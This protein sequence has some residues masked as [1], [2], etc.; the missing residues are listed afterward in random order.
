MLLRI[1]A[2]ALFVALIIPFSL[3]GEPTAD[4]G[5]SIGQSPQACDAAS[6][7]VETATVDV[8]SSESRV[9]MNI[10]I[11]MRNINCVGDKYSV[12]LG[13]KVYS[14]DG[15]VWATDSLWELPL[16]QEEIVPGYFAD[17]T[18]SD[19]FSDTPDEIIDGSTVDFVGF[20]G[21]GFPW[22]TALFDGFDYRALVLSVSANSNYLG[23]TIALYQYR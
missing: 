16:W 23:R 10:P 9:F 17:V 4:S 3:F 21:I 13:W 19:L 11:R 20:A 22:D 12:A 7:S 14:P 1:W 8:D 6:V 15:A 5:S 2:T 18:I